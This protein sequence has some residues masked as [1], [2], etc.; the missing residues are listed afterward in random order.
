VREVVMSPQ[1]AVFLELPTVL[2]VQCKQMSPGALRRKFPAFQLL[3]G[4]L[5]YDTTAG[6]LV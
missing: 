5:T 4:C 1:N 6:A 3:T 2:K